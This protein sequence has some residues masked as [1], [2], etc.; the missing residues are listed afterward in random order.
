MPKKCP[1]RYLAAW[2]LRGISKPY[3][4]LR[5]QTSG[6][7]SHYRQFSLYG[8]FLLLINERATGGSSYPF[9][10]TRPFSSLA[11]F[12]F[13]PYPRSYTEYLP[14]VCSPYPTTVTVALASTSRPRRETDFRSSRCVLRCACSFLSTTASTG[15]F[16]IQWISP[17]NMNIDV[18]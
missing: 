13:A 12:F 8:T 4:A 3:A 9:D 15:S 14:Y 5:F 10:F 16:P 6:S 17:L 18:F 1:A 2:P 7:F 11:P